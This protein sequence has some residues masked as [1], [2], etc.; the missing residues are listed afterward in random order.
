MEMQGRRID[1]QEGLGD[2]PFPLLTPGD[3][4]KDKSGMWVCMVPNGLCG[5]L[6]AHRVTEH[7]DGTITVSPSILVST[8][9]SSDGSW[10]GFLEKGIWR[11]C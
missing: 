7:E 2:T 8:M 11:S 3:Y 5:N 1:W 10:H 6:S 4:G 9:R